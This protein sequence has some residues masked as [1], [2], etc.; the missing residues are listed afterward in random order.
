MSEQS[1]PVAPPSEP[2]R[3]VLC[4]DG[5]WN[6]PEAD[7]I[8]NIVRIRNLIDAKYRDDQGNVVIQQVFYESGVGTGGSRLKQLLDGAT[9]GGLEDNVRGAYR[10]LSSVYRPGLELYIFG[11]SRGAFT[12]RSLAGFIGASG[13]LKPEHCTR[14]NEMKAWRY[15]RT[16][17]KFRFPAHRKMLDRLSFGR[18]RINV[19]GVFDTVGSRGIPVTGPWNYYN[20]RKYGFHDVALGSN[21]DHALHALAI[22]ER[23]LSFPASI[24]ERPNHEDNESVE[25]VWF[26]GNHANVGGGYSDPGLSSIALAWMLTRIEQKG[27]GLRFLPDWRDHLPQDHRARVEDETRKLLYAAG[28]IWPTWRTI[29]QCPTPGRRGRRA[30]L[31]PH[32]IPIGETLHAM[33]LQRLGEDK[34]YRPTNLVSALSAM[35]RAKHLIPV[36]D[37]QTGRPLRWFENEE[38]RERLFRSIPASMRVFFDNALNKIADDKGSK[39]TSE[40]AKHEAAQEMA[41]PPK[42]GAGPARA[43]RRGIR[44]GRVGATSL[45]R[46]D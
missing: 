1:D 36:A 7:E 25:Q 8:T 12:A 41:A 37:V 14:E 43:R 27:L 11:F 4:L 18:V 31:P 23:R 26:V 19:L 45:E 5:T 38:D 35:G 33:V 10:Y 9:G 2:K 3:L 42:A 6:T 21:V 32:A 16:P 44:R 24:W 22:D 28:R 17:P 40:R 15:Y 46:H 30:G 20:R 13:L 29:N 34:T 39:S